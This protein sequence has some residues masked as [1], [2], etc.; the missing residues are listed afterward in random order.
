MRTTCGGWVTPRS[1]GSTPRS[2]SGCWSTGLVFLSRSAA[3]RGTRLRPP[4][5]SPWWRPSRPPTVSLSSSLS[6]GA[7]M[8]SAA[9]LTALDDARL[10]FIVGARQIRA[11]GD[12]EAHFRWESDAFTD[13]QVNRHHHPQK[14]LAE[15]A[16]QD[17]QGRAG[18]GPAHPSRLVES[19]MGILQEASG[20][21][22]PGPDRSGQPGAGRHCRREAAQTH[23]F[24]HRPSR[25]SGS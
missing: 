3:G 5:S 25:R 12:L 18:V 17:S 24:C 11:P 10:R 21:G 4:R 20:P 7:G 6:P 14:G 15:R 2:S 13:G 1:G 16:G 19:G 9:N 22:Q 8:L 23:T